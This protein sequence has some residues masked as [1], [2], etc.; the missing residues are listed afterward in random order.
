MD[1]ADLMLDSSYVKIYIV[2][3]RT[4]DMCVLDRGHD[5]DFFLMDGTPYHTTEL[6]VPQKLARFCAP[7]WWVVM[8]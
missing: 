6:Q 4:V 3:S 8:K 1:F 2:E 7:V 5:V